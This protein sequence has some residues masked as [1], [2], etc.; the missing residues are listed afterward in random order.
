LFGTDFSAHSE[1][2]LEYALSLAAEYS[3]E[4]TLLNVLEEIPPSSDLSTVTAEVVRQLEAPI[5][6]EVRNG[7]TIKPR[8]R[9]GRPYQEIMRYARETRTD[10]VILGVRGR[11]ALDLALFGSTTYRVIQTGP[12]PVLA[13][14]I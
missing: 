7:C 10:L 11:N 9:V 5:P 12:C 4:L 1:R 3:A 8:L 6:A 14:H 2:A 13:V